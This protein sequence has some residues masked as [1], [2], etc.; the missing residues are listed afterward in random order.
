LTSRFRTCA[1]RQQAGAV[2]LAVSDAVDVEAIVGAAESLALFQH[3]FPAQAGLVDFQQQ[4]LEQPR[5][6]LDGKSVLEIMV[7]PMDGVPD[8]KIAVTGH[9]DPPEKRDSSAVPMR[10]A[11]VE[12]R[13]TQIAKAARS[14]RAS[15]PRRQVNFEGRRIKPPRICS[16]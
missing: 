8:R 9:G 14:G 16:G 7:R 10:L 2:P 1:G 15:S 11:G 12:R 3:Q 4:P 6:V 5:F 13:S